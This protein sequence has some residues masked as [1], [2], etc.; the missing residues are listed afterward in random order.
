MHHL[1]GEHRITR[2][3]QPALYNV[4]VRVTLVMP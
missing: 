1:Q 3:K 4:V 2:S